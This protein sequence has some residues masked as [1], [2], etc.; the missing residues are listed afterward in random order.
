MINFITVKVMVSYIKTIPLQVALNYQYK[1]EHQRYS[2]VSLSQMQGQIKNKECS[3]CG[4]KFQYHWMLTR[5]MKIHTGEKAFS[6]PHCSYTAVQKF[7]VT[8]HM[9]NKHMHSN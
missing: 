2:M 3:I 6:C 9:R 4:Y 8:K 5:H 1:Q 7:D